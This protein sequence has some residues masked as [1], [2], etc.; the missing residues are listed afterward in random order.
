MNQ[1]DIPEI[2]AELIY[3]MHEVRTEIK[4]MKTE[5]TEM[6][7]DIKEV[8]TEITGM[9]EDLRAMP[10][11]IGMSVM[12]ALAPYLNKILDHDDQLRKHEG[13]LNT[14]ENPTA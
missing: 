5:I 1:R 13:R 4:E 12:R 8:K 9:R 2:V 11:Q 3:E 7:T 14:L 10:D 6:K